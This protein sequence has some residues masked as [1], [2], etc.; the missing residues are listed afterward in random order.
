MPSTSFRQR[1]RDHRSPRC[2]HHQDTTRRSDFSQLPVTR[3]VAA[4][5]PH[6]GFSDRPLNISPETGPTSHDTPMP[7][8][9][10]DIDYLPSPI[11]LTSFHNIIIIID[12][13]VMHAG[14][15]LYPAAVSAHDRWLFPA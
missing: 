14:T 5:S 6:L 2:H 10:R 4:A 8:S 3:A 11:G 7:L 12:Y 9:S 15:N 1:P 13:A